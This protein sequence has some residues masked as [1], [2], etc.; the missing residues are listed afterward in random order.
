MDASSGGFAEYR[1]GHP[2]FSTK[3]EAPGCHAFS[4]SV[5]GAAGYCVGEEG[6]IARLQLGRN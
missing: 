4:F 1:P 6:R 3:L 5:D 2:A